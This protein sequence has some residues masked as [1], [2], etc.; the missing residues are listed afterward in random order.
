MEK[1]KITPHPLNGE[2]VVPPSKSAAHRNIIAAA[3]S[4]G[5][6]VISPACHSDDI[7]ATLRCITALGA[8]VTE[9]SQL[10]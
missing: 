2:V 1:I 4:D 3:L 7:D 6:S 5:V 9:K 8:T 10:L